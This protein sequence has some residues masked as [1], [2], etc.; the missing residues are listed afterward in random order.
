MEKTRK[1]KKVSSW[2][3]IQVS[4]S[5]NSAEVW[6]FNWRPQFCG[7]NGEKTVSKSL[8]RP[9][10]QKL[11]IQDSLKP[12][13]SIMQNRNKSQSQHY[14][15]YKSSKIRVICL[16]EFNWA[17]LTHPCTDAHSIIGSYIARSVIT[18]HI[19]PAHSLTCL[20]THHS[21]NILLAHS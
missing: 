6:R 14:D 3:S 7:E 16:I 18:P 21:S 1:A 9:K 5:L 13:Q 4:R 17:L 19:L 2:K 12:Q 20:L 8:F 10:H 11:T 15:C